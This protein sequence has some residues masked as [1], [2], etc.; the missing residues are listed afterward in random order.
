MTRKGLLL[1]F[2]DPAPTIDEEF[3]DW[4][5]SEHLPE[6]AVLPGFET[7]LRFVSVCGGPAYV[8]LYDLASLAVLDSEAYRAVSG[9]RL[10]PWTRRI[11]ARVRPMRMV[12]EQLDPEGGITGP[13]SRLLI[14]EFAGAGEGDA[15]GIAEAFR[16]SFAR[17]A[18]HLGTR[19]FASV[20]PLRGP[21]LAISAFSGHEIPPLDLDAFDG[22]TMT[23][24]ASY[25]PYRR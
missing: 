2:A 7:A 19:L 6:R 1:V 21:I 11:T 17:A 10:S 18:G 20:E 22:R 16:A 15:A 12:A 3:N 9:D 23:L 5:D 13:C 25:R 14:T 24:A 4:Y 8:A